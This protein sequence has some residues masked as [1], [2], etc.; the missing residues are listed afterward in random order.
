MRKFEVT[1]ED[2]G[3]FAQA[4]QGGGTVNQAK[5][6]QILSQLG[7]MQTQGQSLMAIAQSTQAKLDAIAAALDA[8]AAGLAADIQALKDALNAA[9]NG[10]TEADVNNALAPLEAR[11]QALTDLDA[12]NPPAT[13]PAT[14]GGL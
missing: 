4:V 11:V 2:L 10:M 1:L 3:K 13:P 7:V 14:G 6:D 8:A 5:L 12:Q 9:S